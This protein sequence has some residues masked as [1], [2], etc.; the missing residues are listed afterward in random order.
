VIGMDRCPHTEYLEKLQAALVQAEQAAALGSSRQVESTKMLAAQL[1]TDCAR[2]V[3]EQV[4]TAGSALR[5]QLE[6]LV[7]DCLASASATAGDSAQSC[8]TSQW[9]AAVAIVCACLSLGVALCT[10]L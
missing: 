10:V 5:L 2:H 8:R 9:A 4:R 3:T 7:Q 6:R 1:L